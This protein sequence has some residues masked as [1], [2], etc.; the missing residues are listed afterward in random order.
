MFIGVILLPGLLADFITRRCVLRTLTRVIRQTR[1]RRDN[2]LL[3]HRP[4]RTT[5]RGHRG[6]VS[7]TATAPSW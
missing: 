6:I 4:C 7:I 1:W 3:R 5:R 2:I